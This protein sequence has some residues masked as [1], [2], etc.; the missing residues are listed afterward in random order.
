[1]KNKGLS[2]VELLV[3]MGIFA[4]VLAAISISSLSGIR[5][6]VLNNTIAQQVATINNSL[7]ALSNQI[8]S[9]NIGAIS[10]NACGSECIGEKLSFKIPVIDGTP[11]AN[12]MY[13]PD[14]RIKFGA[15]VDGVG[16][17]NCRYEYEVN[18][19]HQLIKSIIC[20]DSWE[21]CG[22]SNC[23]VGTEDLAN[24]PQDCGACGDTVCTSVIGENLGTCLVDCRE[25]GDLVCSPGESCNTCAG[26]CTAL[27][28]DPDG[29]VK[30]HF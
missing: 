29:E 10:I 26:D 17:Q 6:T 19:N 3:V 2:T 24:C 30:I 8:A 5:A 20:E 25:C 27:C 13:T 1:M 9:S 7:A 14:D 22:D 23:D 12:S 21:Y 4:T 11:V 28:S 16:K 18:N 15:T